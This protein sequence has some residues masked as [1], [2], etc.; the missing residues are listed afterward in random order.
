MK[1]SKGLNWLLAALPLILLGVM[2]LVFAGKSLHRDPHIT[3]NTLVGKLEPAVAIAPFDGGAALTPR[4]AAGT[5]GPYVV[6]FFGSWCGPCIEES[7]ML[8]DLKAKG[9]PMV[10]VAYQDTPA[11]ARVFLD[12]HG[13]PFVAHL[14]DPDAR[15]AIEFGVSGVPETFLVGAD[16]K[17]ISKI[18]LPLTQSTAQALFEQYSKAKAS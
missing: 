2:T 12:R 11:A 9:V 16:G 17:I 15:A 1:T 3:P 4:Q 8:M 14:N 18:S 6:N 5:S 10:G 13:D 7:P